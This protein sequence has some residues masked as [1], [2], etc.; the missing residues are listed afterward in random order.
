MTDHPFRLEPYQVPDF[1]A[2]TLWVDQLRWCI[3]VMPSDDE[4]LDF[5]ASL[6]SYAAR[7]GLSDKQAKHGRRLIERVRAEW[8]TQELAC[9]QVPERPALAAIP[10]EGRA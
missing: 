6:L 8:I 4:D 5:A 10:A 7:G 1:P 9:Q 3:A 2:S